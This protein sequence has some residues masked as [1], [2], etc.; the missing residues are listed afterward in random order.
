MG[1][2]WGVGLG[3][4]FGDED[5]IGQAELVDD[6]IRLTDDKTDQARVLLEFHKYFW[7]N[8]QNKSAENKHSI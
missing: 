6:V 1:L 8:N 4:S 5:F 7:R 3:H 2:K